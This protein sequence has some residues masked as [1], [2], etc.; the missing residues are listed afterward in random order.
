MP[1]ITFAC[2]QTSITNSPSSFAQFMSHQYVL[3]YN[4]FISCLSLSSHTSIL[5]SV[6][7]IVSILAI[8]RVLGGLRANSHKISLPVRNTCG[9]QLASFSRKMRII[10]PPQSFFA[11]MNKDI[12]FCGSNA[13]QDYFDDAKDSSQE[14]RVKQVSRIE[15]L[16][17]KDSRFK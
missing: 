3:I 16:F 15:E 2:D 7:K 11:R 13:F 10:A 14:S 5:T 9:L 6:V 12:L 1:P 4:H 8:I 17:N